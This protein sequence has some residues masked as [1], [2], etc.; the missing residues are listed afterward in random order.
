MLVTVNL[1]TGG[2]KK[3]WKERALASGVDTSVLGVSCCMVIGW[4]G[5]PA[6]RKVGP[7]WNSQTAQCGWTARIFLLVHVAQH[8][9]GVLQLIES[10]HIVY[11]AAKFTQIPRMARVWTTSQ[12]TKLNWKDETVI[13]IIQS[14]SINPIQTWDQFSFSLNKL[15]IRLG[16]NR[17]GKLMIEL[18]YTQ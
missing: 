17:I 9:H 14:R 7:L 15:G 11:P 13:Q 3:E 18:I 4:E 5:G 12:W 6:G 2:V 1:G 10:S 16:S 8:Y